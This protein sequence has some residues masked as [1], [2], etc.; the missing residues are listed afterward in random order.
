M[1]MDEERAHVYMAQTLIQGGRTEE[2]PVP[3]F[4][5]TRWNC[6]ALGDMKILKSMEMQIITLVDD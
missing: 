2:M 4:F 6:A 1:M 5:C 3:L